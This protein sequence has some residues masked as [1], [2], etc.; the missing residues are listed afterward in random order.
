MPRVN[1]TKKTLL[2]RQNIRSGGKNRRKRISHII[3]QVLPR[4]F[5]RIS[6]YQQGDGMVSVL[7]I[8]HIY[9]DTTL[10]ALFLILPSSTGS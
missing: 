7:D 3:N 4:S 6:R 2:N 10:S 5:G 9:S 1:L 8:T